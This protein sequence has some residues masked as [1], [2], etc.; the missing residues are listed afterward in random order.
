MAI[1]FPN[2]PSTNPGNGGQWTDPGGSGVWQ[3]EIINGE[4]IWTLVSTNSGGGEGATSLNQLTD[5]TLSSPTD[6]QLIAYNQNTAQWVN[7]PRTSANDVNLNDLNDVDLSG[8]SDGDVLANDNGTWKPVTLP[9][10]TG[11]G[12]A[13]DDGTPYARQSKGWVSS[14]AAPTTTDELPEGGTNLYFEE[15]P[16]DGKQYGRENGGW[17]EITGGGGGESVLDVPEAPADGVAY[18]RKNNAWVQGVESTTGSTAKLEGEYSV[19]TGSSSTRAVTTGQALIFDGSKYVPTDLPTGG[20]DGGSGVPTITWDIGATGTESYDFSG[21]GFPATAA[22]P[23]LAVVRGQTY[24]FNNTSG[25]HPFQIQSTAGLGGTAYDTGVTDNNTVGAVTF[26]VPM[27]APAELFY[28]CTANHPNM[29]GTIAVLENSAGGGEG[30]GISEAPVDGVLYAR[31]DGTWSPLEYKENTA[32]GNMTDNGINMGAAETTGYTSAALAEADGWTTEWDYSTADNGDSDGDDGLVP[33]TL[34]AWTAGKNWFGVKDPN[35][36]NET[37]QT[38][39]VCGNGYLCFTSQATVDAEFIPQYDIGGYDGGPL[40]NGYMSQMTLVFGFTNL[41]MILDKVFSKEAT[42]LNENYVVL[43]IQWQDEYE[44]LYSQA[45]SAASAG[46]YPSAAYEGN[47]GSGSGDFPP[48]GSTPGGGD[49]ARTKR[50]RSTKKKSTKAAQDKIITV[51]LWLGENGSVRMLYGTPQVAVSAY[52][53]AVGN[54]SAIQTNGIYY[55]NGVPVEA[56]GSARNF[57]DFTENGLNYSVEHTND[58]NINQPIMNWYFEYQPPVQANPFLSDAPADSKTYG[59]NNEKWVEITGGG[60]GAAGAG[61]GRKATGE[62]E[63]VVHTGLRQMYLGMDYIAP[64][65]QYSGESGLDPN[66]WQAPANIF[67]PYIDYKFGKITDGSDNAGTMYVD[68]YNDGGN[69]YTCLCLQATI[70]LDSGNEFFFNE[71]FEFYTEKFQRQGTYSNWNGIGD[72]NQSEGTVFLFG[73][74][75]FWRCYEDDITVD[76][77][78]SKKWQRVSVDTWIP[79]CAGMYPDDFTAPSNYFPFPIDPSFLDNTNYPPGTRDLV[80]KDFYDFIGCTAEEFSGEQFNTIGGVPSVVSYAESTSG[81]PQGA[82]FRWYAQRPTQDFLPVVSGGGGGEAVKSTAEGRANG[83]GPAIPG[84]GDLESA[85]KDASWVAPQAGMVL[86]YQNDPS[87]EQNYGNPPYGAGGGGGEARKTPEEKKKFLDEFVKKH[88]ETRAKLR[89]E[90][91]AP[92][93]ETSQL[94]FNRNANGLGWTPPGFDPGCDD[95]KFIDD[96]TFRFNTNRFS[97]TGQFQL[98]VLGLHNL[99]GFDDYI[100]DNPPIDGDTIVYDALNQYWT[101]ASQ[102]SDIARST[103]QA[104]KLSE[105]VQ[106]VKDN[107]ELKAALKEALAD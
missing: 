23:A 74:F 31:K 49:E 29:G 66:G 33:I 79:I 80:I 102:T 99:W 54:G 65:N 82:T 98:D 44:Y 46:L 3:V 50:P 15:A 86:M 20:G 64:F 34:P 68:V 35:V 32:W 40:A 36:D 37:A 76:K 11:V 103:H 55:N 72:G 83:S 45:G 71:A 43:R 70:D 51:E 7:V 61:A 105:I 87:Y 89:A 19:D 77:L 81:T 22:N 97:Y 42:Y 73:T 14:P 85:P 8:G 56:M 38:I 59:R 13:P 91:G 96:H 26:V 75:T 6:G 63:N 93:S 47:G 9:D 104:A 12:E 84:V 52:E 4:A 94:E 41:D 24:V 58:G 27:D 100:K 48:D 60:G 28:Q 53:E 21:P 92:I 39:Y 1:N 101:W 88:K 25:S 67:Q 30:G 5:V 69:D 106:A 10:P 18:V 16:Q 62:Y 78:Q 17:T 107:P 95:W 90:R 57:H 2:D